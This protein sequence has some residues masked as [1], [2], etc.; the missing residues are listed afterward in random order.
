MP[1]NKIKMAY[2]AG[3]FRENPEL[4]IRA[5]NYLLEVNNVSSQ[6]SQG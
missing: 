3:F 5:R 6:N 2:Y 4:F 1:V